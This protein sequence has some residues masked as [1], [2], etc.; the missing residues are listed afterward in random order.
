LSEYRLDELAKVSGT[1]ARNIRAYRDR[2]LLDAPRREGRAA[3]YDDRHVAQLRLVN[4]LL[5]KGFTSAHI[6]EFF[7]GTRQGRDLTAI[8]GLQQAVVGSPQ[9]GAAVARTVDSE[10]DPTPVN[11][12]VADLLD[13]LGTAVAAALQQSLSA[14]AADY[15]FL[16]RRVVAD[17]LE[18]ALQRHV[19]DETSGRAAPDCR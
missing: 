7:E 4:D 8:L 12:G 6:A 17:Q 10:G 14:L 5:R 1:S 2:G 19:V 15:R 16:V 11:A 13:E 18:D 9:E 3:F